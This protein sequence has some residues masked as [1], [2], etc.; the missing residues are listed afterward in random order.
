MIAEVFVITSRATVL[1]RKNYR[2]EATDFSSRE[3]FGRKLFSVSEG[4]IPPHF[5]ENGV[6]FY[7]IRRG[8]LFF[9]ATSREDV[10]TV[11]VIEFLSRLYHMTKDFCGVVSEESVSAN[12]LLLHEVLCD[13]MDL[14]YVQTA[15]TVKLKPYVTIEPV[16][17]ERSQTT[18]EDIATRL[19][20]IEQRMAPVSASHKPAVQTSMDEA[21]KNEIFVDVVERLTAVTDGKGI[22]SRLE[23]QG[24]VNVKNFL[25]GHPK[26]KI[27]LNDDLQV[28]S[29]NAVKGFGSS[30]TLDRCTFHQCVD[31][32]DFDS[33]RILNV[34]PPPGEFSAMTYSVQGSGLSLPVRVLIFIAD[35][36]NSRD[37][38]V[39][40]RVRCIVPASCNAAYINLT[41]PVPNTV[42][43]IS[44]HVLGLSH[45]VHF[46]AEKKQV[47][48]NIRRM[49]GGEESVAQFRLISH[50]S[51]TIAKA[52][53]GPASVDFEISK[54]TLSGLQ[55]RF[56]RVFEHEHSYVPQRWIRYVTVTDS[57]S[58]K[59]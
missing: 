42:S 56:L 35:I 22:V 53:I 23:V 58:V 43:S 36:T 30:A 12:I 26:V 15:S 8:N 4:Y 2:E 59:T 6:H 32:T 37:V 24:T 52:D 21:K 5:V 47:V 46:N 1:L 25:L 16:A 27:A 49:P 45:K 19:F 50:T 38:D 57:F 40:V 54:H 10:C 39:T 29:P 31:L 28:S 13:A 20:G 7:C 44:Q 18:P 14:G 3:V 48:W 17:V 11:A 51:Q 9:V 41:L 34:S 33:S 55:I